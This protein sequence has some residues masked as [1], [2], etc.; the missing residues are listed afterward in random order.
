MLVNFTDINPLSFHSARSRQARLLRM[1]AA[2][3]V[4]KKNAAKE[5]S[6]TDAFDLMKRH[7]R[8]VKELKEIGLCLRHRID[9]EHYPLDAYPDIPLKIHARYSRLEIQ[10]ALGDSTYPV[11]PSMWQEGVRWFP[12]DQIDAFAFT[13]DKTTGGFSPSTRYRDYAIC[14]DL[15]HWESQSTTSEGSTTGQRYQG[16]ISMGTG[17]FLFARIRNDDRAFWFLGPARYVKHRSNK[18]MQV[19][20]RLQQP[21]SGDLFSQFRAAV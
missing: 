9:H 1:L 14:T 11:I 10:S 3:F 12:D 19:T 16:H 13:L 17:I 21:L 15:I 20:W 6:L 18:P 4:S 5:V 8:L 2:S 7:H